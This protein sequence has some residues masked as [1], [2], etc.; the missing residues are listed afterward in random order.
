VKE[1]EAIKM[2]HWINDLK[3]YGF[4]DASISRYCGNISDRAI[5]E[6]ANNKR[7]MLSNKNHKVLHE[8]LLTTSQIIR[9]LEQTQSLDGNV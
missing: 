3:T 8:W 5:R 6:F 1:I 2:R 4:T 7:T 9:E